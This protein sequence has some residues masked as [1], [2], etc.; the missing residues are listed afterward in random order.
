[1]TPEKLSSNIEDIISQAVSDFN[2]GLESSQVNA[3]NKLIS[4]VKD[5]TLDARG[6]IK[7]TAQNVKVLKGITKEL[8]NTL[9]TPTYKKRVASYLGKFNLIED[10]QL[11]YFNT[12]KKGYEASTMLEVIKAQAMD[13]TLSALTEAGLETYFTQP[14][15]YILY[16]NISTGG[17]YSSF[18]EELRDFILGNDEVDGR[19]LAYTKQ[20]THDSISVFNAQYNQSISEELGLSFYK[21]AGGS[22]DTTREFCM[23]RKNKFFHI[24]EIKAWGRGEKCCG[25]Q[26]PQSKNGLPYWAG[27]RKGTNENNILAFRGGYGCGHQLIAVSEAVVP[28][29]V[30][31]RAKELNS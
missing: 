7:K 10:E 6:N 22:K 24:E 27:M 29:E 5:L 16:R 17:N 26:Y 25:L 3:Y 8:Q 13:S 14:V 15:K 30:K 19:F 31:K 18:Q 23:E 21:Y 28:E 1:M 9:L 11:L 12:I 4:L 2:E 20:I